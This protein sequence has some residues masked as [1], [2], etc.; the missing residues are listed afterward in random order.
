M[1]KKTKNSAK[2][3]D[4]V[5]KPMLKHK[6]QKVVIPTPI[7]A[8]D[9]RAPKIVADKGSAQKLERP[10]I[11]QSSMQTKR[12]STT[13]ATVELPSTKFSVPKMTA[14]KYMQPPKTPKKVRSKSCSEKS[15]S[16]D[17]EI[18]MAKRKKPKD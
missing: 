6:P 2:Q 9:K 11:G 15:S 1:T 7:R 18:S 8:S 10:T 16:D 14:V 4:K 13:A 5:L 17:H 12:I 3:S